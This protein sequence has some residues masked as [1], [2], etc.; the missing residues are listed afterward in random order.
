MWE[1]LEIDSLSDGYKRKMDGALNLDRFQGTRA[2]WNSNQK[3]RR[4]VPHIEPKIGD[5]KRRD[6]QIPNMLDSVSWK[7]MDPP[8]LR[9]KKESKS[10]TKQW[11]AWKHG[12]KV[13]SMLKTQPP[14]IVSTHVCSIRTFSRLWCKKQNFK[15]YL[16]FVAFKFYSIFI[17]VGA[18]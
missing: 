1:W 14:Y 8:C 15:Y 17:F 5:K 18:N 2:Y 13:Y 9:R 12:P 3:P 6:F 11:T 16:Q 10:K 4:G 7:K